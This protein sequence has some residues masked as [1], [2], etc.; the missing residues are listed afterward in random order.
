MCDLSQIR[1]RIA[2]NLLQTKST[3][4]RKSMMSIKLA[5]AFLCLLLL[6]LTVEGG[7]LLLTVPDD[8]DFTVPFGVSTLSVV[9]CG[10]SATDSFFSSVNSVAGLG[11]CITATMPVTAG[12]SFKPKHCVAEHIDPGCLFFRR[13]VEI[14]CRRTGYTRRF[15]WI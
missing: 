8:T 12:I 13:A 1:D 5:T 3:N 11:R 2:I 7:T 4:V 10:A 14:T 15:W 9:I 6:R